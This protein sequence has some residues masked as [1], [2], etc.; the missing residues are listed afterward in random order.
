MS[1][2]PIPGTGLGPGDSNSNSHGHGSGGG[3]GSWFRGFQR[4][5][6]PTAVPGTVDAC[7]AWNGDD[8]NHTVPESPLTLSSAGSCQSGQDLG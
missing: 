4:T 2:F 3:N 1:D 5:R 6:T 8:G 7:D